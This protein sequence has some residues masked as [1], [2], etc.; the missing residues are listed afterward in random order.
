M[1]SNSRARAL[2]FDWQGSA[3]FSPCGAYR[4]RLKRELPKTLMPNGRVLFVMLNPSTADAA[5]D[6]ATIR[7]CLG[8]ARTL[9]CERLDVVNL[10]AWRSTDPSELA[11]A[12]DPIGPDNDAHIRA[13]GQEADIIVC[14]WG[15]HPAA[16]DRVARVLTLLPRALHCL[17]TTKLG[18]PRH[19]LY[20]PADTPLRTWGPTS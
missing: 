1:P 3:V 5:F 8:F 7:R 2:A 15:A 12:S 6:D 20:V 13:C 19:P 17:G 14:A 11:R 10:F 18:A 9:E 16:S 4:Y